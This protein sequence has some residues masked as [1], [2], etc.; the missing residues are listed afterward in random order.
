MVVLI[1]TLVLFFGFTFFMVYFIY[2]CI[3]LFQYIYEN[4]LEEEEDIYSEELE[5]I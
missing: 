3:K 4:Q 2:A 5:N 1:I